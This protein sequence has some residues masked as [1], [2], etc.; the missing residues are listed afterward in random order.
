LMNDW[1]CDVATDYT[2][3]CILIA[4]AL[5]IIERSLLADRPAFF[6]TA[7]RRGGGK[8]TALVMLMM[9]ITGIRPSAAAWSPNEE[10]RRKALLAYLMEAVPAIIWDNILRGTQI[11]CRY[12]EQSCT[13]AFYSDRRLGV[14]ELVAVS[15]SVI[16]LFTGNNIAP[17]GDF[18]S[19]S[20]KIELQIDRADP[21]NRDFKHSDPVG[22]TDANRSK[23]LSALYTIMLG[24]PA[25]RPGS[26]V[27]IPTR[28]KT[29]WRLVGSAV[30]NAADCH[31]E[32]VD[33]QVKAPVIDAPDKPPVT[34]RFRDLF[35]AQED[36]DE[37]G[38]SL[39]EVLAALAV[40]FEATFSAAATAEKINDNSEQQSAENKLR[41]ATIREFFFPNLDQS[42]N[43]SPLALGKALKKRIGEPVK[44][45]KRTLI[46][47]SEAD[48]HT[49]SARFWVLAKNEP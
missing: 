19:R 9:A 40:W 44:L 42:R 29:W 38:A 34:I 17:K 32:A 27:Q 20:L 15:A 26:N 7:G 30:E 43:V 33:E 4:A 39:A 10:E 18:A 3:R 21:E 31:K 1:L 16:H 2:G 49:R 36:E 5:T 41:A 22:W 11:S 13:T 45:E 8:T 46:L 24:N 25:L 12:I 47:K 35:L 37:E 6:V 23:I 14:S 48:K 28:F